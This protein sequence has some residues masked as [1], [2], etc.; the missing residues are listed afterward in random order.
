M[1]KATSTDINYREAAAKLLS[2]W[3]ANG[4][5]VIE[6]IE[7]AQPKPKKATTAPAPIAILNQA[8]NL[9]NPKVAISL[10][11]DVAARCTNLD[12]LKAALAAFEGCA[13]KHKATQMVFAD[14]LADAP[15]MAIGEAPGRDEDIQGKPFVGASGQLLDKMFESIGLSRDKNLYISN[16]VNWRPP[17]N[18]TP[19]N[20]ELA[21]LMPFLKKHIELKAPKALILIG[22]VAAKTVLN[23]DEGITRLRKKNHI[24]KTDQ[25][26]EIPAFCI[27][28]PSFLLKRPEN[29]SE[30]W[31][32]LLS[33]KRQIKHIFE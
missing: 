2:W 14:G 33:I 6:P 19:T 32:D 12:A 27:F 15:V 3:S 7:I 23:T 16:C 18:R 17:G 11:T 31:K 5:S 10:A 30:T 29:K 28:H 21:I 8:Q 4:V 9:T 22:A 24:Y 26:V 25:G 13:L 1:E 20:E